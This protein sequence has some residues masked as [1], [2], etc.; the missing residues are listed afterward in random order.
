M[1]L[2][3]RGL[4]KASAAI[5]APTIV[6]WSVFGQNA[7]SNRILVGA[8]GV[9]RISRG[10]DMKEVLRHDDA[11]IVAVC[12]VDTIRL[13]AGKQLVDARY[14][15]KTAKPYSGTR[16]YHDYRELLANKEIDAVLISTPDH[17]HAPQAVH[18]VRAGK[19][20][21]LQ[22]PAA[23]TIAEGRMMADAVKASGR[24][25]QIGSSSA[26]RSPGQIPPRLRT[27]AQR[28]DRQHPPCRSR[29]AWRSSGSRGTSHAGAIKPEL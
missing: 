12:D 11:Q 28:P 7:P 19:H 15:E 26:G 13:G 9:G 3:R 21:Y 1:Q 29:I 16:M 6:P 25:L 20:V 2:S 22:K 18:A 24:V 10:H 5:A 17:Q 8:I 4:I 23:L 27:G 14:A